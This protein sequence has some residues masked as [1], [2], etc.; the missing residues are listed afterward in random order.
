MSDDAASVTIMIFSNC[1]DISMPA[2]AVA[3]VGMSMIMSTFSASYHLREMVAATSAL[4]SASAV[5]SSI[6]LS[7]ILPPNSS[8]AIFAA[9]TLPWPPMSA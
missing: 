2:S 9:S 3:D 4:F 6:G 8:M 5:T 7:N 1:F